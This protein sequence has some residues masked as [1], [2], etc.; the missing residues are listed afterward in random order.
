MN[1]IQRGKIGSRSLN[2]ALQ[3]PNNSIIQVGS[4]AV[5]LAVAATAVLG[6]SGANGVTITAATK[7]IAFNDVDVTVVQGTEVDQATSAAFDAD[8]DTLI[9]T[10]GADGSGDPDASKATPTVVAAAIDALDEWGAAGAG[11]TAIDTGDT[12]TTA[13]GVDGTLGE[14]EALVYYGGYFYFTPT[15]STKSVSNWVRSAQWATW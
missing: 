14:P 8:A 3:G 10:L 9:V 15:R 4:A 13:D 6:T 11:A 7:G 1:T 2:K 5:V 12:A